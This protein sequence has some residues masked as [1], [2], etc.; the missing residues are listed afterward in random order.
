VEVSMNILEN[1]MGQAEARAESMPDGEEAATQPAVSAS[2]MPILTYPRF[3]PSARILVLVR[4]A[5]HISVLAVGVSGSR[6]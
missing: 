6:Q 5:R 1:G 2:P 4:R 3:I